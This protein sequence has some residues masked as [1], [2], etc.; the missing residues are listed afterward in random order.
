MVDRELVARIDALPLANYSGDAWRHFDPSRDPLS[1]A[2]ARLL[3]GR[4][5]PPESFAVLYLGLELET[6]QAEFIRMAR[7]QGRASGDFLPRKLCRYTIELDQLLDLRGK[8]AQQAVRLTTAELQSDDLSRC[9]AVGEATHYL[10]RSGILA[11]SA[12][13]AGSVLAVF[14]ERVIPP[15]RI[16]VVESRI[17]SATTDVR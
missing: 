16:N 2:G 14:L 6:V 9:Q 11:P 7:R 1:G 10:G 5:N 17:W 3:G 8:E 15:S 4:W 12:A 13:S